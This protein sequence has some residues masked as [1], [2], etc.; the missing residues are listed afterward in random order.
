MA[1]VLVYFVIKKKSTQ[2]CCQGFSLKSPFS[3]CSQ[4]IGDEST[5]RDTG[6]KRFERKQSPQLEKNTSFRF[7][8]K[9]SK[10]STIN[11]E[12][13][14]QKELT[15]IQGNDKVDAEIF[16]KNK[17]SPKNREEELTKSHGRKHLE[18]SSTAETSDKFHS[19]SS[20]GQL[21]KTK[22]TR[23]NSSEYWSSGKS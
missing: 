17:T 11:E 12:P 6:R 14:E 1:I 10:E 15:D 21:K 19:A 7:L 23:S 5:I 18:K 13:L 2:D 4:C 16:E 9:K 20:S 22:T 3:N 8:R